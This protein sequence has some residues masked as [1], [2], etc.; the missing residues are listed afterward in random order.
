MK[1]S[2][3]LGLIFYLCN[4][5]VFFPKLAILTSFQGKPSSLTI[6]TQRQFH[7]IH[8]SH[9]D[10]CV[11]TVGDTISMQ[12]EPWFSAEVGKDFRK[13]ERGGKDDYRDVGKGVNSY[14]Q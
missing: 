5:G 1:D 11:N 3:A 8:N 4:N 9:S 6:C 12:V 13:W 2:F 14:S 10:S 7:A